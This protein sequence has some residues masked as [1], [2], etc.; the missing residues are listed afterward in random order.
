MEVLLLTMVLFWMAAMN[1]ET[2]H[3]GV[4]MTDAVV[5]KQT[6]A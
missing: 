2:S 1:V 6:A 5:E 3:V 4:C